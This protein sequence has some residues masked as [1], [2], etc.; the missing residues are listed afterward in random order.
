MN[1]NI[2]L[3]YPA[4]IIRVYSH[5]GVNPLLMLLTISYQAKRCH[6]PQNNNMNLHPQKCLISHE[7]MAESE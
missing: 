3:E 1:T 6:I 7:E 2:L 5:Y 4:S